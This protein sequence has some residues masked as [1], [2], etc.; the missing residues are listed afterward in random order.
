LLAGVKDF[1]FFYSPELVR[2]VCIIKT[3][4]PYIYICIYG[5]RVILADFLP[6]H[7]RTVLAVFFPRLVRRFLW[8]TD[9]I[10]VHPSARNMK[11]AYCHRCASILDFISP[12][13]D[14]ELFSPILD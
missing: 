7:M 11:V 14:I 8:A 10:D 4:V 6:G 5:R 12:I 2:Q 1:R 9:E 3:R 13:S